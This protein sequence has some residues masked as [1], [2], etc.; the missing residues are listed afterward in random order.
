M[1]NSGLGLT[2]ACKKPLGIN[3]LKYVLLAL[4]LAI[5]ACDGSTPYQP[6][7][8][9]GG[10]SDFPLGGNKYSVTARGNGATSMQQVHHIAMRRALE[11][12]RANGDGYFVILE[13]S[14]DTKQRTSG[15]GTGYLRDNNGGY[16]GQSYSFNNHYLTL[17]IELVDA[18]EAEARGALGP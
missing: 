18:S 2:L 3:N 17:I 13:T 1:V 14:N 16:V 8:V 10:Y 12:A 9:G 11:I 4:L 7:G 5:A 6:E 15:G